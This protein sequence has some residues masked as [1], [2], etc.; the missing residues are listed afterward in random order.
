MRGGWAWSGWL[1]WD[2]WHNMLPTFWHFQH[3]SNACALV[4]VCVRLSVCFC[5]F[6]ALTFALIF[7][8]CLGGHN[9][10]RQ[11]HTPK[12][13]LKTI[14]K[15]CYQSSARLPARAP[16]SSR[17]P[18]LVYPVIVRLLCL[19]FTHI[20]LRFMSR[21]FITFIYIQYMYMFVF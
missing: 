3:V 18:H 5:R 10:K 8:S 6:W 2:A 19:T 7:D 9:T 21:F 11:T 1:K 20:S 4:C 16:T 13:A 17:L 15:T 12:H 14:T